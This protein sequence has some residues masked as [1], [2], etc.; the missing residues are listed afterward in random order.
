MADKE[1]EDHNA[2]DRWD[3]VGAAAL[4]AIFP[5]VVCIFYNDFDIH[6]AI[7]WCVVAAA[8]AGGVFLLSLIINNKFLGKLVNLI[9]WIMTVVY[10]FWAYEL[11]MNDFA[12]LTSDPAAEKKEAPS[13]EN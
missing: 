10:G 5:A 11:V 8:A 6:G 13:P 4:M 12:E 9:G 7:L 3:C 1:V 2:F